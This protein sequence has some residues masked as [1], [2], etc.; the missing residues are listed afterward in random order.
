MH[1]RMV[2]NAGGAGGQMRPNSQPGPRQM[3]QQQ[4]MPGGQVHTHTHTHTH[5][6]KRGRDRETKREREYEG[7]KKRIEGCETLTLQ[8]TA[9]Q[10]GEERKKN[11]EGPHPAPHTHTPASE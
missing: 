9:L 8:M 6:H 2:A 1:G 7:E 10:R 3:L 5:T 4:M 11:T